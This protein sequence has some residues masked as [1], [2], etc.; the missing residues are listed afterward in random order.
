MTLTVLLLFISSNLSICSSVAF[1]QLGNSNHVVV[2]VSTDF[3]SNSYGGAPFHCTAYDYS[4]GD[5]D[6]FCYYLSGVPW[7]DIFKFGSFCEWIQVGIDEY[8]PHRTSL[9]Q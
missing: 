2:S 8:I 4:R 6:G 1:P 5:W 3:P 9:V 7:D